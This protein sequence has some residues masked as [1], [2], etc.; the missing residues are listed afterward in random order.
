MN[1]RAL[2]L[3]GAF[4]TTLQFPVFA[5][6]GPAGIDDLRMV[7]KEDERF[8]ALLTEVWVL[9]DLL[10]LQLGGNI[11]AQANEFQAL[12][13]KVR[14]QRASILEKLAGEQQTVQFP[15][16]VLATSDRFAMSL[17]QFGVK[18]DSE[19][20][21]RLVTASV[22]FEQALGLAS[23]GSLCELHP[24]RAVCSER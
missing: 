17:E 11:S 4:L 10:A 7:L 21:K 3:A 16:E 2:I 8:T 6:S 13:D 1:R 9:R 15:Q 23:L 12:Q 22:L 5:Q 24:F 14:D 19:L 20:G 18:S